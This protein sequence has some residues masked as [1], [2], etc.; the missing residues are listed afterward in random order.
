MDQ[1]ADVVVGQP[2]MVTA[3]PDWSSALCASN[4]TDSNGNPTYPPLCGATLNFPRFALSDG[5]RLFIADGGNDR[6][7]IFNSIPTTN[8][9]TA[10]EVLGQPD[11]VSDVITNLGSS[12]AGTSIDN[13]G[14]VD[15]IPTPTS[16]AFDGTNLYVA[17]P[18]NRRVLVFT[19]GDT[20]ASSKFRGELGQRNYPPG[21]CRHALRHN[22]R[23]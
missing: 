3:V 6:V 8:G 2:L 1:N 20:L 9:A 16:L 10:D 18:Y 17:D 22:R 11:L 14:S 13:T 12:V 19:P 7:L 23:K 4:G 15:T 5:T 21:R